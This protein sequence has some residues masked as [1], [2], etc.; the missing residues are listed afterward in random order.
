MF[1]RCGQTHIVERGRAQSYGQR[2]QLTP[3]LVEKP[4]YLGELL[5]HY[6]REP[7][8]LACQFER[9]AHGDERLP[10]LIV[11]VARDAVSFFLVRG[12]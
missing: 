4:V 8:V 1:Q 3:E 11:K 2:M 10:G 6:R 5:I 9:Q 7:T 12:L